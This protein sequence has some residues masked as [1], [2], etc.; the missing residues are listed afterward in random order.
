MIGARGEAKDDPQLL[1][2]DPQPLVVEIGHTNIRN[3]SVAVVRTGK[4]ALRG[5]Y[6]GDGKVS[7]AH[8]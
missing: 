5:A 4:L 6:S 2:P 8:A 7:L 1:D 3:G